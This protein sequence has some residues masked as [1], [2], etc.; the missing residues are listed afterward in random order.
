MNRIFFFDTY[1]L[2]E[3]G[4]ENP[5][6]APYKE[7]VKILLNNLNLL[8]VAYV[9]N[10]DGRADEANAIFEK[11]SKY[12]ID[13]D[14]DILIKAAEMKF[15]H[16]KKRIS[17]IDCIGYL[18]AKKHNAKFLTGDESFRHMENVEFIK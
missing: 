9:L 13:Y 15:N 6:Y 12:N 8:E 17:F 7:N 16:L 2:I 4:R 10:R 11:F 3:I 18:L 5:N 1:A 14:E